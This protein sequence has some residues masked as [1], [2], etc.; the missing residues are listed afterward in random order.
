MLGGFLGDELRNLSK[1]VEVEQGIVVGEESVFP[2]LCKPL[3]LTQEARSINSGDV[4]DL[5]LEVLGS[6]YFSK[7]YVGLWH[8]LSNP[9]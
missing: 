9:F 6:F 5:R 2:P 4:P 1:A 3:D 7:P 8:S